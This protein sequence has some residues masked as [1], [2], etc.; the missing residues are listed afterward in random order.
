MANRNFQT[1]QA[2]QRGLKII[3]GSFNPNGAGAVDNSLNKGIGYS[4]A[5]S[6]QGKFVITLQ[7]A[8]VSCISVTAIVALGTVDATQFKFIVVGPVDV[9]GT[10]TIELN[11]MDVNA[12]ALSDIA[13]D[14]A[15]KIHFNLVLSNSTVV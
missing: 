2:L 15:N 8:Y 11:V 13:F 1:I 6:A 3:S 12:V 9:A 14:A 4:V 10:K 5:R 7:D